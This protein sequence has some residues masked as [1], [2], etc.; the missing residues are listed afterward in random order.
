VI[1]IDLRAQSTCEFRDGAEELHTRAVEPDDAGADFALPTSRN[2][3]VGNS[4]EC[5]ITQNFFDQTILE[6]RFDK[7]LT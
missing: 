3:P 5:R 7:P 4:N 1:V 2:S 6:N